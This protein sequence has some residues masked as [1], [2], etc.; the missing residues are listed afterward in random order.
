MNF[1][2]KTKVGFASA[3]LALSVGL[4]TGSSGATDVATSTTLRQEPLQTRRSV[5]TAGPVGISP[6][7]DLQTAQKVAYTPIS[8]WYKN[9]HWWKRNA[10]VVGGAAGG[11]L[12]GGLAGGGTGAIIG[13]TVGGGGG[14]LY[15]RL[16]HHDQRHY[17]RHNT[18]N[19][20]RHAR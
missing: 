5:P 7:I 8:S 11:A 14:Y 1:T 2:H 19:D 6:A 3:V 13:G 18:H 12:I 10:P 15:K 17:D 20:Y 16:K 4:G 9:K